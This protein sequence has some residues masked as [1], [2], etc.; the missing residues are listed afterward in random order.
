MPASGK[1]VLAKPDI[2][3][4]AVNALVAQGQ[5]VVIPY[6]ATERIVYEGGLVAAIGRKCKR[7]RE[8]EALDYVLGYPIGNDVSERSSQSDEATFWRCKNTDTFKPMG[9]WIETDVDLDRLET[10]VRINESETIR[11]KTNDVV[12]GVAFFIS[13]MSNYL[14]LYPGDVTLLGTDGASPNIKQGD[15]VDIEITGLGTLRNSFIREV[16]PA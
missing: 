2:G 14:T 4:R 5:P 7:V 13:T 6:D 11:F 9:P 10:I 3:F 8:A 12:F 16:P 15:V 1:S